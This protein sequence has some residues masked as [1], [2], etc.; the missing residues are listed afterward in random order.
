MWH[1]QHSSTRRWLALAGHL[2]GP[3]QRRGSSREG[4]IN[5]TERKKKANQIHLFLG[6]WLRV[7]LL[8][9]HKT[10]LSY[11][12]CTL[13]VRVLSRQITCMRDEGPR[14]P[15]YPP[16]DGYRLDPVPRGEVHVIR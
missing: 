4:G 2:S 12:L 7:A 5:C 15:Y 13:V 10:L 16:L 9:F 3:A 8:P 1:Q 11:T 14:L 6:R